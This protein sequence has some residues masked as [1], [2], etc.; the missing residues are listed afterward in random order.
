MVEHE[1]M[2]AATRSARTSRAV[3]PAPAVAPVQ[4]A[5]VQPKLVVGASDD[6]YEREA[7]SI[8]DQVMRSLGEGPAADDQAVRTT[9]T[10]RIS[11]MTATGLQR[12]T[13]IIG[14]AGGAVDTDTERAITAAR[15][16]G[17]PLDGKIRRRMEGA[18]GADFSGIRM[19]VGPQSDDLNSR[20]QARAFTSGSD[21]FIRRQDHAPNTAAG[22]RL[23]AH[24]LAHTV[25]QGAA[26]K[27]AQRSTA[28]IAHSIQ[29]SAT[30]IQRW[31]WWEKRKATKAAAAE[32]EKRQ[33]SDA[34]TAAKE[35]AAAANLAK[36]NAA[37]IAPKAAPAAAAYKGSAAVAPNSIAEGVKPSVA[38]GLSGASA[39]I[40]AGLAGADFAGAAGGAV[41]N[42]VLLIDAGLGLYGAYSMD[43]E[44]TTHKDAGMAK[45]AGRKAKAMGGAAVGAGVNSAKA[46]VDIANAAAGG[47][48]ALGSTALG[49]ASGALGVATGSVQVMQ[50]AWRGGQAAIKLCRL[51]WGRGATMIT[52]KGDEWKRAVVRAEKFKLAINGFKVA[53]GVL[54][55]AAGALL[56]VSNPIGWAIGIAG[57]IAGGVLAIS[58]IVAKVKNAR[59]LEAA[60]VTAKIRAGA[61]AETV[62]AGPASP[63]AASEPKSGWNKGK[64]RVQQGTGAAT[65]KAKDAD[66]KDVPDSARKKAIDEANSVARIACE[67]A[68]TAGEMREALRHGSLD[69]VGAAIEQYAKDPEFEP[70]RS[71]KGQDDGQLYDAIQI[72]SSVNI[73][74]EQ[75]LSDSGQDLIAGKLSK[76]DSM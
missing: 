76:T 21:I 11:R 3:R 45:M 59:D 20:I 60:G 28:P 44:A 32:A 40:S 1:T 43:A 2:A 33:K 13:A 58:K 71:I 34:A 36:M 62:D 69:T 47:A 75:A 8:A 9:G 56:I 29:R 14:E 41:L 22:Q 72:L 63:A 70:N 19:H 38:L 18:M 52:N 42:P 7:D 74:H 50:G 35:K 31:D 6:R 55:I 5:V 4:R 23:L 53:L 67:N 39:G 54:G 57:A 24:E 61:R 64:P 10:S 17:T 51:T 48:Q 66:G 30:V 12:A 65:P 15:S 25:Q 16:G 49:A 46:G 37:G 68:G 27:V 73:S 26:P